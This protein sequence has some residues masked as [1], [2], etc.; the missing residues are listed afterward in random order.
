M[1][2]ISAQ[3][4]PTPNRYR[5]D[6]PAYRATETPL[7]SAVYDRLDLLQ[8]TYTMQPQYQT[9]PPGERRKARAAFMRMGQ[10]ALA[11]VQIIQALLQM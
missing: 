7:E 11:S 6:I 1:R 4:N 9:L 2:T 3:A 10:Q 5:L 8:S